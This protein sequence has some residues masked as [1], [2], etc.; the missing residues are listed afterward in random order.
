M[1]GRP[2]KTGEPKSL[3]HFAAMTARYGPP[4]VWRGHRLK[5]VGARDDAAAMRAWAEFQRTL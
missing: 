4:R 2:R 5:L 1:S 3:P